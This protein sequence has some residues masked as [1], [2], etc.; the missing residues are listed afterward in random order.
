MN[1]RQKMKT[2]AGSLALLFLVVVPLVSGQTNSQPLEPAPSR[3]HPLLEIDV[4]KFGYKP[5]GS[6]AR[7]SF[8]LAFTE[9]NDILTRPS[10]C[11]T[12]SERVYI[13]TS[14]GEVAKGGS[15]GAVGDRRAALC[16]ANAT[17]AGG[18]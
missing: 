16:G 12:V 10:F 2:I 6:G 18:L 5:R 3:D 9:S 13:T 14:W 7:D 15:Q 8:S 1:G 11:T 17:G 4:R